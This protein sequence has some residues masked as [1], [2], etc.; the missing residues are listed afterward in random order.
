MF[1]LKNINAEKVAY[2]SFY[3]YYLCVLWFKMMHI[4]K[5]VLVIHVCSLSYLGGWGSMNSLNTSSRPVYFR[6]S[7]V[8]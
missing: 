6:T 2:F 5:Q 1:F 3:N 7:S 8:R 4:C